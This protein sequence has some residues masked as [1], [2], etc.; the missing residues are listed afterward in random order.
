MAER[1]R[2]NEEERQKRQERKEQMAE[3]A[4]SIFW[5]PFSGSHGYEVAKILR[6]ID[7]EYNRV[8]RK[9][10]YGVPIEAVKD[11]KKDVKQTGVNIWERVTQYIPKLH[12]IKMEDTHELNDD[13]NEKRQKAKIPA[14]IC[15]L[16]R[17]TEVGYLGIAVKEIEQKGIMLQNNDLDALDK[18][19]SGCYKY[20]YEELVSLL[21]KI[22]AI[23]ASKGGQEKNK[24]LAAAN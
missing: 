22:T 15:F 6:D 19:I 10:G 5:M 4:G 1:T 2:N 8:M 7:R 9:A 18:L 3:I 17:S 24:S 21:E 23:S 12:A 14:S 20:V 11:L 16:P 13:V